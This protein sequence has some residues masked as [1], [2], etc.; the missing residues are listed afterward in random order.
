MTDVKVEP[1]RHSSALEPSQI[2]DE[3]ELCIKSEPEECPFHIVT[4]KTEDDEDK[5]SVLQTNEEERGLEARGSSDLPFQPDSEEHRDS[6]EDTDHSEDYAQ[7]HAP[8]KR[9]YAMIPPDS[10]V[11]DHT[12]FSCS[13]CGKSFR[14]KSSLDK[15]RMVHTD[16]GPCK[17]SVCEK[18]FKQKFN[19][20]RHLIDKHQVCPLCTAHVPEKIKLHKHLR[21]HVKKGTL[22]SSFLELLSKPFSCT[23]CGKSFKY[24]SHLQIHMVVHTGEKPFR[25]SV[26]E[27]CFT[28]KS[29]LTSH[30]IIHTGEKP[31]VCSFCEKRFAQKVNL[32]SHTRIHTGEKPFTCSGCNK[33]FQQKSGLNQHLKRT[34]HQLDSMR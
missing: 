26:C 16:D 4:V 8:A 3:S 34:S 29:C 17:C 14:W 1:H 7:E 30:M 11:P 10:R 13:D 32:T 22:N 6:C 28:Q 15:H 12:P 33:R 24:N 31:F 2:K 18:H 5:S 21:T 25:C 27:K 9:T 23:D 19:L 20:S